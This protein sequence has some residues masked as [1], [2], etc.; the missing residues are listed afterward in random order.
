MEMGGLGGGGRV[1][2]GGDKCGARLLPS[3]PKRLAVFKVLIFA[4]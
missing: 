2:S 3:P 1:G 4:N